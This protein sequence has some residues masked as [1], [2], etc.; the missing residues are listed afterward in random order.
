MVTQIPVWSFDQETR[1]ATV[2]EPTDPQYDPTLERPI[3]Y[4]SKRLNKHE[5]N[6][7]PTEL[8]VA[9]LV[10][11][12]RKIR[13][14]VDDAKK[15]SVFTDH[16]A[17][18]DIA[19]Q[20]NFRHSTPHKQNLRLVRASLYLSQFPQLEVHY[21]PGRLNIIPD[22][23]SRLQALGDDATQ[24]SDGDDIYDSLHLQA[25]ML[26]IS[27][28]FIDRLQ[29]GYND[30]PFY[31]TKFAEM[32][33]RY[34]KEGSLP[35]E[36]NNLLLEDAELHSFT[37][38]AE[39]PVLPG[40]RRYILYLKEGDKLRLCIPRSMTAMFLQMAHDRHNHGG[41]ERT[42]QRLRQ[43]YF[44]KGASGLIRDYIAHCPS[45]LINKPTNYTPSGKLTPITA[46]QSPWELVT[47]DFVV[48]L[49]ESRPTSGLW[50][51]LKGQTGLPAYDSFLT[52]TDKLT[53]YVML[54]PGR[55]SWTAE[56]WAEAYFEKVFPVFGVPAA[57]I[58]DRGSVFLSLFWT[59][60][61][62]RMKTDCIA[63]TAYNPR[64]DGQSERTN[65][66]VEIALRHVVNTHQ[67]NWAPILP[68]IQF[69]MNNSPN[70]STGRAPTEL[71]MGFMPRAAIDIPTGHLTRGK[72]REAKLRV[73]NMKIA[74]EEARDAIMLAEFTMAA[75]YDKDRRISDICKGDYVFV[76]F[77]K[78]NETG[79]SA[80]GIN[81]PKLG[82]QRVGPF[83]VTEMVGQNACRVDLPTDWK[84]WPVISIRHLIKAPSTPDTFARPV[85]PKAR[86]EDETKEI[87]EI[88]DMR[89]M[90]GKKEYFVKYVGLPITR[91]EWVLPDSVE[92]ARE[93][94]ERFDTE[95]ALRT[96]GKRKR[97]EDEGG[98][99]RKK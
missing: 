17:T 67:N 29:K 42:Y 33:R 23:L 6:Y 97:A 86:P 65:Q 56:E 18:R 87:E 4:L 28:D 57:I 7:W 75:T 45:C 47:M 76:N 12:V 59:T 68:D 96:T 63:T 88:L 31:K 82:P 16:Q 89:M 27:D 5:Q 51:Q 52:I 1:A 90:H 40:S 49:P 81:A 48:K 34:A 15:V 32:K 8:E 58:S 26:R 53:K 66:V 94:I 54:V 83:L 19:K 70:A 41:F 73:G 38:Q 78:R 9:G 37:P 46:P 10:W 14:L 71:M 24:D 3:C 21:I 22:A 11:T 62:K 85:P 64:S 99:K 60:V 91:C 79:Y 35:I 43:T 84:V 39:G 98:R 30:D 50:S 13:H 74:R 44:M 80:A 95:S 77:A 92:H 61:F 72:E 36:F 20:T 2:L 55:E 93:K 25:S 69:A